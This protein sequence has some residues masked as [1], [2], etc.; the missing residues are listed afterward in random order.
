MLY[1]I[2][3]LTCICFI[4]SDVEHFSLSQGTHKPYLCARVVRDIC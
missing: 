2:N 3:L 4:T 1:F